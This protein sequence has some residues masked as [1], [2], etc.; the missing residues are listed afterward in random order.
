[1]L[2]RILKFMLRGGVCV[3]SLSGGYIILTPSRREVTIHGYCTVRWADAQRR[4]TVGQLASCVVRTTPSMQAPAGQHVRG[5][6]RV[7]GPYESG[8]RRHVEHELARVPVGEAEL[9]GRGIILHT[10]EQ[11]QLADGLVD[12]AG[13]VGARGYMRG[14]A[15][16]V[17]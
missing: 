1:M 6:R 3:F 13:G 17:A 4:R 16:A 5:R 15:R 7:S 10:R 11:A 9:I 2:T 8:G 12:A 14:L